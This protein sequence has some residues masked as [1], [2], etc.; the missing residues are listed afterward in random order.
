MSWISISRKSNSICH[1]S[2]IMRRNREKKEKKNE[3]LSSTSHTIKSYMLKSICSTIQTLNYQIAHKRSTK[4]PLKSRLLVLIRFFFY[5]L[6]VHYAVKVTVR[7]EWVWGHFQKKTA[8]G[9]RSD[10]M[11][12]TDKLLTLEMTF[13][14]SVELM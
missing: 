4:I 14:Y 7:N 13:F 9:N 1:N 10:F 8:I 6:R 3:M 11:C 5:V 2:I 12:T